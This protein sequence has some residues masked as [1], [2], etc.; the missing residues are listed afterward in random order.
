MSPLRQQRHRHDLLVTSWTLAVFALARSALGQTIEVRPDRRIELLSIV[1]HLAQAPA[2]DQPGFPAYAHDVDSAFGPFRDQPVVQRVHEL[3]DSA[4]IGFGDPM[5]FALR[6]ADTRTLRELVPVTAATDD[7]SWRW[8]PADATAFLTD[9][10]SFVRVATTEQF[11]DAHAPMYDSAASRLRRL[12]AANVDP[13]WM[14]R[15][16]GRTPTRPFVVVPACLNGGAS[17]GIRSRALN[18]DEQFYAILGVA[19]T[20]SAGVPR[21]QAQDVGTI[22]HEFSHSVINPAVDRHLDQFAKAGPRVL[23]AVHQQ[24][25]DQAY[26]DWKAVIDE[27]LVRATVVRYRLAHDGKVAADSEIAAQQAR[28]FVWMPELV[29]VLGRYESHRAAYPAFDSFMPTIAEYWRRLPE[30]LPGLL[31]Q[32]NATRP[33]VVSSTPAAGDSRVDPSQSRI[34]I[35]FD[36]PMRD[37]IMLRPL[38]TDS[39]VHYPAVTGPITLDPSRRI[40]TIPVTLDPGTQYALILD[41]RYG[42]GFVS[43]AGVPLARYVLRFSTGAAH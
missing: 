16:F 20:D 9:L 23:L 8:R 17:Y 19:A 41:A 12:V 25:Q 40:L 7:H 22:I 29:G 13:A 33:R 10:R 37:G 30:R 32:Y 27:S 5:E 14:T 18:G 34:T 36:Q 31:A 6:L 2:Y 11:L 21:F 1:F 3:Q 15:F 4:G 39:A 24:M 42:R 28:G 43:A 38:E 26:D 35:R